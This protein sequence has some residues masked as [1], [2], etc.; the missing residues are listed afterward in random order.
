MYLQ[1][2]QKVQD[3][4]RLNLGGGGGTPFSNL[5]DPSNDSMVPAAEEE[6]IDL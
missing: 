2:L 6:E 5:D 3:A 4:P 1:G